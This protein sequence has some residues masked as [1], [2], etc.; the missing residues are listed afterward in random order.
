MEHVISGADEA[1]IECRWATGAE[2]S[3]AE[4]LDAAG[5]RSETSAPRLERQYGLAWKAGGA[6]ATGA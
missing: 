3:S 2:V 6:T 5:S 4:G 1:R